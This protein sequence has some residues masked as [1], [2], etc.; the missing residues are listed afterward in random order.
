[1][2][3]GSSKPTKL[4]ISAADTAFSKVVDEIASKSGSKIEVDY[5]F[6]KKG[7]KFASKKISLEAKKLKSTGL[8]EVSVSGGEVKKTRHGELYTV[9][10]KLEGE[11]VQSAAIE[12]TDANG[13]PAGIRSQGDHQRSVGGPR[14]LSFGIM[15][16]DPKR[17]A[18][19][20]RAKIL[21]P[22]KVSKV[23]FE[24]EFE[25]LRAP[26]EQSRAERVIQGLESPSLTPP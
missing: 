22:S 10:L 8:L 9:E 11:Y 25:N 26:V 19:E 2:A 18:K 12:I 20:L 15:V 6:G 4:T 7:R 17:A 13:K 21:Y 24:F 5:G 3:R 23:P 14:T 1:M 16:E